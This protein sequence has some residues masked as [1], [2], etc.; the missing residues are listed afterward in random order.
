MEGGPAFREWRTGGLP[1]VRLLCYKFFMKLLVVSMG[2]VA[3]CQC[4]AQDR[5]RINYMPDE[6][7]AKDAKTAIALANVTLTSV[8]GAAQIKQE[9]PLRATLL[10]DGVWLVEGTL[11]PKGANGGVATILI[12][13]S[14]G[15]V[16]GMIHT[17]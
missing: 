13:K 17:R 6:G 10:P 2:F 7:I 16:L 9:L 8:Y 14:D 11:H 4:L 1:S 12:R 3:A 15:A 5:S